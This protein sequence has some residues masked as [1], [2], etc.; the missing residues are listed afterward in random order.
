MKTNQS[1]A[2]E[3]ERGLLNALDRLI[4]VIAIVL[5]MVFVMLYFAFP[6][7][8]LINNELLVFIQSLLVNLIPI[9]LLFIVSYATYRRIQMIRDASDR[10]SF[11]KNLTDDLVEK[12]ATREARQT[13]LD[14]PPVEQ[15]SSVQASKNLLLMGV[16]LNTKIHTQFSILRN[17]LRQG[18][19]IKI[20]LVKPNSRS[21][22]LVAQRKINNPDPDAMNHYIRL[23][24]STL[25]RLKQEFPNQVHIH[26]IDYPLSFGAL[27]TDVASDNG[28]I[29]LEYYSFKTEQD[30]LHL[31]LGTHDTPWF[32]RFKEQIEEL[33]AF[34]EEWQYET[35]QETIID[36]A[37]SSQIS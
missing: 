24:L 37:D 12:I 4:V 31:A 17:K 32:E 33:W 14:S 28:K 1:R 35:K 36:R 5:L 26:V 23:T 25:G 6:Y 11:M 13:L 30:G 8:P 19:V 27:T 22:P 34:S 20:L 18:C 2:I 15:E 21:V 3:R 29:F 9:P 10:E 16:S 7:I